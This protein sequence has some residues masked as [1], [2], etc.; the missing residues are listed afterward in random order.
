[1][2]FIGTYDVQK[3]E[4]TLT[5]NGFYQITC[6]FANGARARACRIV[7]TQIAEEGG[8]ECELSATRQNGVNE[9]KVSVQLPAGEY[10][11]LVYDDDQTT[12]A[13]AGSITSTTS[14]IRDT[15]GIKNYAWLYN[16]VLYPP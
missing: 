1:M 12:P 5:D 9:A 13:Y 2:L 10:S 6:F 3:V 8:G 7:L 16:Y 4:A 14:N 15:I 11:L